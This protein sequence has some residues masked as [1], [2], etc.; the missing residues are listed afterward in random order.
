M[1]TLPLDTLSAPATPAARR[2]SL[3]LSRA[4]ALH[5]FALAAILALA[6]GLRFANLD[7]LGYANHYYTAGVASMLAPTN[8]VVP[9]S[10]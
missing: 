4:G 10:R 5:I 2:W 1:G 9:N 3:P 8:R 6:A 7:A